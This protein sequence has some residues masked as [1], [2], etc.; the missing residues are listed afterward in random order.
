M[1]IQKHRHEINIYLA[2]LDKCLI[3]IMGRSRHMYLQVECEDV[4]VNFSEPLSCQP[5]I[6]SA[7][8]N[9]HRLHRG[10]IY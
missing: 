5:E 6:R 2:L 7:R 3:T 10:K 1:H 4:G 9:T 8:A